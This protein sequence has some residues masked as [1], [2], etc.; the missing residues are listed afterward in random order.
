MLQPSD[1]LSGP[2]LDPLKELHVLPVLGV[3]SLDA[4]N[5][6]CP[7]VI[8]HGKEVAATR[9]DLGREDVDDALSRNL[10]MLRQNKYSSYFWNFFAWLFNMKLGSTEDV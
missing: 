1:H 10:V 6:A 5:I 3:S 7:S 2:P 9:T 8:A 4:V